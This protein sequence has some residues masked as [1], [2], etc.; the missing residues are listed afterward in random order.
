M[1][2]KSITLFYHHRKRAP[3]P[4]LFKFAASD[5]SG[6]N[7][8]ADPAAPPARFLPISLRFS[9]VSIELDIAALSPRSLCI[10]APLIGNLL[11]ASKVKVI[12]GVWSSEDRLSRFLVRRELNVFSMTISKRYFITKNTTNC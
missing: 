3:K 11:G 9:Q 4:C 2:R 7:D 1:F 12:D 8:D 10:T 6:P 5:S